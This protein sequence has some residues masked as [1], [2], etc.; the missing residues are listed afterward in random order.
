[1]ELIIDAE[2]KSLIR[3]LLPKEYAQLEENIIRDGCLNPLI[4]WKNII[5]DGHNRYEIC[6]KHNIPFETIAFQFESRDE[7]IIWI[8]K[9]Q[10]G[11]RN[12]SEETR[13]Y[14]IGRQYESEKNIIK[15][16]DGNNQ[17]RK[18]FFTG[19]KKEP[20]KPHK[21]RT[22]IKIAKENNI[23]AST[24]QK[25]AQFSSAIDK[26]NNCSPAISSK[27]LSGKYKISH[28]N[29]MTLA[30]MSDS[31]IKK[32]DAYIEKNSRPFVEYS[33][34]RQ[35]LEGI[36]ASTTTI[37]TMPAYDPDATL[38]ELY[39]TIPSWIS[40]INRTIKNTDFLNISI[41]AKNKLQVELNNMVNAIND[42][43]YKL[44]EDT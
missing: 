38:T 16:P 15:N 6:T 14:L 35:I 40:S 9:N 18:E 34:G 24:V 5:I 44:E 3:P 30:N 4:I 12:I 31:D 7:A 26:L 2:F 13:K 21:H 10:L 17:Y 11:R 27:I 41:E 36:G 32:L 39:L 25:Y 1:M 23:S 33:K 20:P 28:E 22:A 8:C 19:Y 37:K 42:I 43:R 29:L